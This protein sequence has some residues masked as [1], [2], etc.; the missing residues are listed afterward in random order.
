MISL[1]KGFP[2]EVGKYRKIVHSLDQMLEFINLYNGKA[3]VF[4][5]V[6]S[7]RT[8]DENK[9]AVYSSAIIDKALYDFDM[10]DYESK[11]D[12]LENVLKFADFLDQ[13]SIERSIRFSGSGF[14]ILV[15]IKEEPQQYPK[16]ALKGFQEHLIESFDKE[17]FKVDKHLIG[18]TAGMVRLPNTYNTRRERFCI[19]LNYDELLKGYDFVKDLAKEQRIDF[20]QE[21]RGKPISIKRFDKEPRITLEEFLPQENT[22][23]HFG[24]LSLPPCLAKTSKNPDMGY[25]DRFLLILYLKESGWLMNEVIAVLKEVLSSAKF[26]HCMKEEHQVEY[27]FRNGLVF[28]SCKKLREEGRCPAPEAGCGMLKIYH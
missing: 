17:K 11:N 5:S 10:K 27:I 12:I 19:Y 20:Q 22:S 21:Q 26:Y 1:Y 4:T 2:R 8:L 3:K 16:N 7:F 24:G 13:H 15:G 28:P 6:F 9:K 23:I 25:R 14:H 18:N